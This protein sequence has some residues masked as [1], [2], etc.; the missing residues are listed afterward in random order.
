MFIL[1]NIFCKKADF[2]NKNVFNREFSIR[3]NNNQCEIMFLILVY[4]NLLNFEIKCSISGKSG[5]AK[6]FSN[7]KILT[8]SWLNSNRAHA[9]QRIEFLSSDGH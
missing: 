8:M 6:F 3:N 4:L 2:P 9:I 7:S 5:Y 1:Y